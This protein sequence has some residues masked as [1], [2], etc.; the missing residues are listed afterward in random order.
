M[1]VSWREW[2]T[3]KGILY[4]CIVISILSIH[5]FIHPFLSFYLLSIIYWPIPL[6]SFFLFFSL[7]LSLSSHPHLSELNTLFYAKIKIILSGKAYLLSFA[8]WGGFCSTFCWVQFW[9]SQGL[10]S[11]QQNSMLVETS[12]NIDEPNMAST[13]HMCL[14]A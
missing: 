8:L 6:S 13:E 11:M 2:L 1:V 10:A 5:P 14:S 7:P 3:L 9:T 4:P 12:C